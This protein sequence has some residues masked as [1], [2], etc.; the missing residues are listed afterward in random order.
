MESLKS[1]L[2]DLSIG[3]GSIEDLNH[4]TGDVIQKG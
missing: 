2:S 1:E 3:K 4:N